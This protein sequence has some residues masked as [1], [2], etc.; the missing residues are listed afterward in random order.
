MAKDVKA[1]DS[2]GEEFTYVFGEKGELLIVLFCGKMTGRSVEA[3]E[4]CEAELYQ[5][6]HQIILFSFRDVKGVMPA[7][8]IALARIQKEL[9]AK[10]KFIGLC[11][12]H[13]EM[14]SSLLMS[15]IIRE[16]EIYNNI[17]EAWKELSSLKHASE[18][19]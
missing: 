18:Q 2:N 1:P 5:K 7:V 3:L 19:S 8:H 15:G 16:S 13:P 6:P 4:R 12:L 14:K 17:A 10:D 9:R 11:S